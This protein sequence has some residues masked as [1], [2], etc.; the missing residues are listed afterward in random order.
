MAA[1]FLACRGDVTGLVKLVA[2]GI[3]VDRGDYDDRY[4]IHLAAAEGRSAALYFLLNCDGVKHDVTDRWNSTPLDE[5][6]R[7]ASH[8]NTP[9]QKRT[10][11]EYCVK[12]L[13]DVVNG[14]RP[15]QP[16]ENGRY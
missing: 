9:P 1:Q 5:A 14:L 13:T 16:P 12:M 8:H 3:P 10:G 7:V 4:P 2:S 6:K 15:T 11:A